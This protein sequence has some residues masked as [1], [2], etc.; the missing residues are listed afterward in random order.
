[1]RME[2]ACLS[3]VG[4]RKANQDAYGFECNEDGGCWLVADGLG[5][6]A[7]G[8]VASRIAVDYALAR[9]REDSAASLQFVSDCF[10]IV[11][12]A[13]REKTVEDFYLAGMRTTMVLLACN[14]VEAVWGHVGD[15]RLY[16][17]RQGKILQQ[18]RDHSVP[19]ML[20]DAGKISPQEIRGHEDQNRL[21][22]ALGQE[23]ELRPT[24]LATSFPIQEGD[25]ALLC[26]D[27]VW[28]YVLEPEMEADLSV[29]HSAAEWLERLEKRILQRATGPY[30]NYTAI[31]VLFQGAIK[32]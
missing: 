18:T 3:K 2:S 9:F 21:T 11:Q 12:R 17:F 22:R 24:L 30:D 1:M 4:G 31:A 19:Q 6:H 23:G 20:V 15:S 8:E 16:W 5:G 28:T 29:S 27:G 26:S 25:A 10:Q 13:I 14:Q 32:R 7:G